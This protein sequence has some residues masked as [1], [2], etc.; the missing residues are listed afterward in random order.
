M[1]SLWNG[2]IGF[3]LVTIPVRLYA[4][5]E[6]KDVKFNYLH[7]ICHT[8]VKYQKVCPNCHREVSA[9][10]LV[11]GYEYQKG[12]YINLRAEDFEILP[13]AAQKSVDITDFILSAEL[14]P[15][16][17]EKTYYLEPGEGGRKA[18]AL[19]YRALVD[20][21][22]V[23]LGRVTLRS[24]EVLCAIRPYAGGV[25]AMSTM[26]FPDEVRGVDT[27][28][29]LGPEAALDS[30]ELDM[31]MRLVEGMSSVFSPEKYENRYRQELMELIE[32]KKDDRRVVLPKGEEEPGR[33][34][35]LMEALRR[36]LERTGAAG[37]GNQRPDRQ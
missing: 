4:A 12:Q 15:V 8:P 3:G 5:T 31:A 1:R 30:R 23:A 10:E 22:R 6:K 28:D 33:V 25:M 37:Q 14:D 24:K 21:G 32:A 36:S 17:Y 34:I 9:N 26:F 11:W 2:S 13:S 20:A 27:L 18:Y 7:E 35:D 19:L 29:R 16:Y